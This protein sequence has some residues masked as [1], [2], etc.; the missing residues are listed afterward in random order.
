MLMNDA[1]MGAVLSGPALMRAGVANQATRNDA[2]CKQ[3]D[4]SMEPELQTSED[5]LGCGLFAGGRAA[6][7][8]L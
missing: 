8:W 4:R 1:R 6:R 3:I 2:R 7:H 5:E